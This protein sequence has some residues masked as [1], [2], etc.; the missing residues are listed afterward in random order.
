MPPQPN[1]TPLVF[2][3]LAI[4]GGAD[5]D[6]KPESATA[7]VKKAAKPLLQQT[8][9]KDAWHVWSDSAGRKISAELLSVDGDHITVR[10]EKG[11]TYRLNLNKLVPADRTFAN[12]A[13]PILE[14]APVPMAQSSARVDALVDTGLSKAGVTRNG[15]LSE[16]QFVR[17]LYLDVAGRIPTAAE[18]TGYLADKSPDKRSKLIDTLLASDGYNSQFFDWLS[19]MLRLKDEFGMGGK[20]VKSYVYQ[21]WVKEQ[22]SANRHWDTFVYELMTAEG[23]MTSTGPVG[24]LLRDR[25]MPLDNLSNTLTT[26]LG[27]NVACAQC[28][29]HPMAHWT[30][31]NFYE[32][33]AFFGATD[34]SYEK[35][36]LKGLQ[37]S[38]V[39]D[40]QT[41]LRLLGPNLARVETLPTN[42][43]TFPKDYKY[44]DA[45]P[46]SPVE[47]RM[48]TWSKDDSKS[49]AYASTANGDPTKLRDQFAVWLT[50]P[51][52]PR[53]AAAIANRLWKKLFGL[54]VQ[55][56]ISD[57]D[58]PKQS[59]NPELLAH[60]ASEMKRVH[61][62]LREF[63]RIILNSKT[64]Q[65][66]ASP[67][68]KA[69]NA[70]YAFPGPVLR[71][72]TA[73][74]IWDSVLTLTVGAEVDKF[75]LRRAGEIRKLDIPV[76]NPSE[77][78]IVA[79]IAS[80]KAEGDGIKVRVGK[81]GGKGDVRTD[82]FDGEPPPRFEGLTLARSSELT[83]PA[84]ESHF[85]R[86]FGQSDRDV[87]DS[88]STEGGVPQVLLM[89]NGE[90]Q[91]AV[92]S[93]TSTVMKETSKSSDPGE[94]IRHLYLSF[95][96][97]TPT[98][99]E[100][101]ATRAM[102]DKG[103]KT[104]DLCWVLLNTR[105]FIFVQ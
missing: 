67:T 92:S 14:T 81:K 10:T 13:R 74:Q 80:L 22:I 79:K 54:G 33:A 38:G 25:G 105:E 49:A 97:R 35:A 52:N 16:D 96:G 51:D 100:D 89:M 6:A 85:L 93:P 29:D 90:V 86:N 99:S 9:P 56:P 61:F 48:I 82:E 30:Q 58:D 69:D 94:Q 12:A 24:Y 27:A 60:L 19:D 41:L 101:V 65:A 64:Y 75:K 95:L 102:L 4:V 11:E 36:N 88:N 15:P 8:R 5:V 103:L 63:Q 46:G 47:P 20:A 62:D 34:Q 53:F 72:M 3:L 37:K 84:K 57:L 76:D 43:L 78:D 1:R 55:E 21:E 98:P 17:R 73:D 44:D 66:Q 77:K 31:R 18:L 2:A 45:K 50:H 68:P 59:F 87:A 32:M 23:R 71:R 26:F 104:K 39:L 70:P 42:K 40:R 7:A 91:K 28:H 83:Q